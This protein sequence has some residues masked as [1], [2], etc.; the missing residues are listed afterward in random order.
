MKK[1]RFSLLVLLVLLIVC[2][3]FTFT[4][5]Q[6]SIEKSNTLR[7]TG[8]GVV[9]EKGNLHANFDWKIPTN[10]LYIGIKR[11][12]PNPYVILREFTSQ[13]AAFEVANASIE[14]D[15]AHR[16]LHLK[17]DFLGAA[18]N[19]RGRWEID[20]GKGVDCVLLEKQRGI[21]LQ[22]M[23]VDSQMIMVMDMM[24]NLPPEA[25]NIRYDEKRGFLIYT[26]PEK[27]VQGYPQLDFTLRCKPRLMAATYKV[28]GN[29]DISEGGMWVAK[30]VF[31]NTGKSN[32]KNLKVSYKL[33]EFSDWS[34]PHLY[35][36]IVP[37]GY[38]VDLYY[39]VISSKVTRLLTRTPVDVQIKYSYEDE[40]GN[41]YE[42]FS[43]KRIEILGINQIEF[44]NL[45]MEERTGTWADN[46]SNS[47]LLAAWVTH[48]DPPVKALAGMVSQLAGGV[49]TSL[50][51]E[52]AIKFCRALYE[53]E[54][55]NGLVYQTPSGFLQDYIPGQDIKYPR[56][57]LRD[58]SGTCVD[59]AILYASVCEAVGLETI[60]VTIP[61]HAFP[62]VILPG[63]GLLPVECTAI[64]GAAVGQ[65]Q[66]RSLSFDKAVE[67]ASKE[68]QRLQ[69]GMYYL[70]NVQ[71]MWQ[72]GVVSPELPPLKA[73]I[74]Q[75]WGWQLSQIQVQRQ[76]PTTEQSGNGSEGIKIL[77]SLARGANPPSLSQTTPPSDWVHVAHPTIYML[78]L[79]RPPDW[80]EEVMQDPS[81]YYGGLRIT[82]PDNQ[83]NL[84]VYYS[85]VF[86]NVT[87]E[88][89]IR[90]GIHLLTG[91]YPEVEFAVEDNL[92]N[93]V[94]AMWPGAD[95]RFIAFRFQEKVGVLLCMIFPMAG[96]QATQVHLKGCIGTADKFDTLVKEVF[97]KVF[98]WIVI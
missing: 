59:L 27:P 56:D 20:L 35:S 66:V 50:D 22:I 67:F 1:R 84:Y 97:L 23:S 58:K 54:I 80:K 63:G 72:Q 42:D 46:F 21:F 49:P 62:V 98:G 29:P 40:K 65:P 47:P 33:G 45:T 89:G 14:Y 95:A 26:L 76:T 78:K 93:F 32:I 96:G 70:V 36:L 75:R 19:R 73:D 17:A 57:V 18:I 15:D 41:K 6:I 24:I 52:S 53:L 91:S 31:K 12:F 38:V 8:K 92:R 74:V 79:I 94:S 37:E 28:Y 13:R 7:I 87:L 48:L 11:N 88:E 44:C 69:I 4:A 34:I 90:Q 55:A 71:E 39:P 25:S 2:F 82:S 81:G 61:G 30:T 60:L 85:V 68:L 10:A 83:A 77:R 51:P 16:Q 5:A 3:P 43:G 86:A 9:D 64:S